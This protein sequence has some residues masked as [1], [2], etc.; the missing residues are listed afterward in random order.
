MALGPLRARLAVVLVVTGIKMALAPGY[1]STDFEVHRNWLAIT[2]SL[3]LSQWCASAS[4]Q[5]VVRRP[6]LG[7]PARAAGPQVHRERVAVDA[8]LPAPVRLL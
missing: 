1:R 8:G 4:V 6:G 2:G 5:L 3:P 7:S